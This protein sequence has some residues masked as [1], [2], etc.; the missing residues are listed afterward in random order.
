[1]HGRIIRVDEAVEL[2]DRLMHARN[3]EE[4]KDIAPWFSPDEVDRKIVG[5]R[6]DD[7]PNEVALPPYHFNCRTRTVIAR[8]EEYQQQAHEERQG[9][10]DLDV[11]FRDRFIRSVQERYRRSHPTATNVSTL[12]GTL[13]HAY[14]SQGGFE[15]LN[16]ALRG[17]REM[18]EF[19]AAYRRLLEEAIDDFEEFSGTSY[20][21][22]D[23]DP[24]QQGKYTP[25]AIVSWD[26]FSSASRV[27]K[28]GYYLTRNTRFR[29]FSRTGRNIAELS[30]EPSER[31]ILFPP[32]T[33]FEVLRVHKEG[34][35]VYI[36]L[37]EVTS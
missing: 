10:K 16:A 8:R 23:L 24:E 4:V 6:S 3:P 7:L 32:G 35:I 28:T 31:E 11:V 12:D 34:A 5:R 25:G 26:A 19:L 17:E 13:I 33:R 14:T 30:N 37:E 36:D 2:R 1:M 27:Q 9:Q 29:I 15:E 21:S 18:T 22:V 20:R